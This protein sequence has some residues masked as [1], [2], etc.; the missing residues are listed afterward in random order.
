MQPAPSDLRAQSATVIIR[1]LDKPRFNWGLLAFGVLSAMFLGACALALI[2]LETGFTSM[3]VGLVCATLPVPVYI[4]LLLWIDRYEPEPPSLLVLS[5][6]WGG[7]VAFIFSM[8]TSSM[9]LGLV[10]EFTGS[11]EFANDVAAIFSAPLVEES[12]KAA[13][14]FIIYFWR[15]ADFDGVVDGILY[16][17]V[18]ALGFAMTENVLYYGMGRNE[19]MVLGSFFVRGI[20][21]PYAH[22]LFTSMTGIGLG[23]ARESNR[24]WVKVLA[25]LG[26]LCLAMALHATWNASA[27]LAHMPGFL[28][29]YVLLM[30]PAFIGVLATIYFALRREGCLVTENLKPEVACGVLSVEDLRRLGSVTCRIT[31]TMRAFSGGG[32]TA[33]RAHC[34]FHDAAS[35]LAFHR[36]R[37]ERGQLE[38]DIHFMAREEELV[39][40]I[41]A[42]KEKLSR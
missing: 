36:K 8:V 14:L 32:V 17:G 27:R 28:L 34:N 39:C 3:V 19:G 42:C 13:V 7:L 37:L 12:S 5:F 6:C 33:W 31:A 24:R 11:E 23:W 9:V 40:L 25:P 20:L 41:K 38:R 1:R 4:T 26:G 18:V 15:K 22:P 16:A 21:S 35:S 10:Q 30:I 2:S 29:I